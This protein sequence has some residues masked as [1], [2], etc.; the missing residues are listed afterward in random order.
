[1]LEHFFLRRYLTVLIIITSSAKLE[2]ECTDSAAGMR[3]RSTGIPSR[4]IDQQVQTNSRWVG[5]LVSTVLPGSFFRFEFR[6]KL[7]KEDCC[8]GFV[9]AT[10]T[11][12]ANMGIEGCYNITKNALDALNLGT[13][14]HV[15]FDWNSK[16]YY[17]SC[18][19]PDN[20]GIYTCSGGSY[21][22]FN[23][24][25]TANVYAFYPC[26]VHHDVDLISAT[27][28][29]EVK[30]YNMQCR[31]LTV[32]NTRYCSKDYNQTYLPNIFGTQSLYH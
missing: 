10:E 21:I 11:M 17:V 27:I 7:R 2:V 28:S 14:S 15:L 6:V 8:P 31:P 12:A 16:S 26:Y 20:E 25:Q 9:V 4:I 30:P 19:Q 23:S 24:V 18:T 13:P 22:Q 32:E 5:P 1:M 3:S 29:L